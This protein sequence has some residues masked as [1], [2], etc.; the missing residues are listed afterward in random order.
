MP[1]DRSEEAF[2]TWMRQKAHLSQVQRE[3]AALHFKK[4]QRHLEAIRMG[5]ALER[6]AYRMLEGGWNDAFHVASKKEADGPKERRGVGRH[7]GSMH[8]RGPSTRGTRGTAAAPRGSAGDDHPG[9]EGDHAAH[10]HHVQAQYAGQ[11]AL[12]QQAAEAEA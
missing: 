5:Q 10:A 2:V 7:G 8:A 6:K 11:D 9:L 4:S 12:D 3:R 1:P